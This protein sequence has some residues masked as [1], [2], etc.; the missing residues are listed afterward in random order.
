MILETIYVRH[1][2]SFNFDFLRQD[3]TDQNKFPWDELTGV[4]DYESEDAVDE[5]EDEDVDDDPEAEVTPEVPAA[6]EEADESVAVIDVALGDSYYPFVKVELERDITTVVGANESGKSQL[7]T[8]IQCLLGDHEIRPR[9]FCRYSKFFGVRRSMRLPEFGGRF[10]EVTPEERAVLVATAAHNVPG[11]FWFFRLE[12]G[13]VLYVEEEN[14]SIT[15]VDLNDDQVKTLPLPTARRIDSTVV[16][17]SSASLFDLASGKASL[18]PRSRDEWLD[19]FKELKR[20]SEDPAAAAATAVN[21]LLPQVGARQDV[22]VEKDAKSLAL[23]RDLLESVAEVD[24]KAYTELLKADAEDDG[25]T[26]ALTTSVTEALGASLNFQK[27]WS[28]DRDFSLQVHKDAFHLVFTLKDNSGQT[29]TFDERS[30]GMQYFLSY[31]IQREAYSPK[32]LARSE[33][34]LMD[35][36]DAYL[37]TMGQQDLMRVFARYA[38]PDDGKRAAQVMYVTHSPFLIDKNYPHRIRV[39]QKGLGEEGTRVVQKAAS[40]K[41]EPLRSAFSSFHAD[42]AF[43]GTCNILVEGPA[44]LI[45]FSG[46]SAGMK[47]ATEPGPTLDL[48]TLTM[49]PVHG[50]GNYRYLVHLTRGRDLDRPA[51][52]VLLDSDKAGDRAHADLNKL[53]N[54][55][56]DKPVFDND[57]IYAID[58][59]PMADMAVDVSEIHEPEDLVPATVARRALAEFV[60]EFRSPQSRKKILDELPDPLV[61]DPGLRLYDQARDALL[62]ASKTADAPLSV[63]KIEFAHAVSAVVRAAE[64]AEGLRGL[65]TNFGALFAELNLLQETAMERHTRERITEITKRIVERFK[66]DHK[67][68]ASKHTVARLLDEIESHLQ[69][70]AGPEEEAVRLACR[71]IREEFALAD[72]PMS[73]VENFSDLREQLKELVLAPQ[74]STM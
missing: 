56:G 28:Q 7:I 3:L 36:P 44:D 51:I 10:T 70:G 17:P 69:G 66:R 57:L 41:Y 71:S 8:A 25:Y 39:L 47:R 74:R 15:A 23:V 61:I 38:F 64:S 14:G 5:E 45:L 20:L 16:L 4:E 1:F 67:T 18:Q 37:S 46:I 53:E 29:Y 31:F 54:G 11:D 48:N 68:R 34:L 60:S 35:E 32:D 62:A 65:Y 30:G 19:L 6:A 55:F 59:L 13:P 26:S 9:D 27:W 63:G 72:S 50:A 12:R 21:M 73:N 43:I 24:A 33:I 49:V 52:V 42:T 22:D 40:E 58:Q 2:R